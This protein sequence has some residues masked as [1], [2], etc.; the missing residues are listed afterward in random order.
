MVFRALGT[1]HASIY[2]ASDRQLPF[3]F[4]L[5]ERLFHTSHIESICLVPDMEEFL[6]RYTR[7]C[8]RSSFLVE[9]NRERHQNQLNCGHPRRSWLL[10]PDPPVK[11]KYQ[12]FVPTH[13]YLSHLCVDN[14]RFDRR[15]CS[16]WLS[17]SI[18]EEAQQLL[19]Q[20]HQN[21]QNHTSA[22]CSL[23]VPRRCR[24]QLYIVHII[25]KLRWRV[26]ETKH[27]ADNRFEW[28]RFKSR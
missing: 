9:P 17:L 25:R 10:L 7:R 4:N 23:P 1:S 16:P 26:R 5:S 11:N 19:S 21:D 14:S 18:F 3:R 6:F 20:H 12:V 8:V 13:M 28:F 22:T 24:I 27:D 2:R 15:L